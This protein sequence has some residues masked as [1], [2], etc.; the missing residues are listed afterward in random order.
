MAQDLEQPYFRSVPDVCPGARTGVVIS[1]PDYPERFGNVLGQ[2]TQVD[3]GR[4]LSLGEI[5]DRDIQVTRDNIIDG[6][7]DGSNLLVRRA[8]G[9]LVVAFG[10]LALDVGVARTRAPEQQRYGFSCTSGQPSPLR[11]FCLRR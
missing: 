10:F 7:L 6:R 2:L 5:L 8:C 1:D 4:C 11:Q 9:E 3:N